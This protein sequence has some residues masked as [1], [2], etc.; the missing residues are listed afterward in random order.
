MPTSMISR[1][2]LQAIAARLVAAVM[3][4]AA[5]TVSVLVQV[6]DSPLSNS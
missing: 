6:A 5:G 3:I 1:S 2:Q 4:F